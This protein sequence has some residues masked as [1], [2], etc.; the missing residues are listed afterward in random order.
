MVFKYVRAWDR[1][2]PQRT[3]AVASGSD[4]SLSHFEFLEWSVLQKHT[5]EE[6]IMN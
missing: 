6:F 3:C 5:D 2:L 1:D 4:R